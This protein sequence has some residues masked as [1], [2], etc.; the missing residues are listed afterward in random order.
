LQAKIE[1]EFSKIWL[2][3]ISGIAPQLVYTDSKEYTYNWLT[4]L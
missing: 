1:L 2:L 4:N 3:S